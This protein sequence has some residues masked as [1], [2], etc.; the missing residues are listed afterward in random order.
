MWA[1]RPCCLLINFYLGLTLSIKGTE[2]H[3]DPSP[4]PSLEKEKE[5]EKKEGNERKRITKFSNTLIKIFSCKKK[6]PK[7]H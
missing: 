2:L 5:R 1:P 6:K 7:L 4:D 3:D